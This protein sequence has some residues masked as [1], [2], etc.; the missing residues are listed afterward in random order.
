MLEAVLGAVAGVVGTFVFQHW[1]ETRKRHRKALREL[2]PVLERIARDMLF[3]YDEKTRERWS[4]E[5]SDEGS[6][7]VAEE[8]MEDARKLMEVVPDIK[9]GRLRRRIASCVY[10][11]HPTREALVEEMTEVYLDVR[12]QA[13]PS[14]H[15]AKNG[16]DRHKW[17]GPGHMGFRCQVIEFEE[18]GDVNK[19]WRTGPMEVT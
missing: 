14:V 2:T 12:R 17:L 3:V 16:D 11:S 8:M 9:A 15:Y 13:Y 19:T 5:A 4:I 6:V 10:G 7:R 18:H 1:K